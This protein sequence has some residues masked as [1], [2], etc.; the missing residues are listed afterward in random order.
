MIIWGSKK[1]WYQHFGIEESYFIWI[2]V[3]GCTIFTKWVFHDPNSKVY[4]SLH[5]F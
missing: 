5:G 3:L 4:D 1:F 2:L